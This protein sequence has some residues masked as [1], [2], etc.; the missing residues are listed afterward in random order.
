M[1]SFSEKVVLLQL[2]YKKRMKKAI[3]LFTLMFALAGCH[4]Q[5]AFMQQLVEIDSTASQK[6]DSACMIMLD[7]I[8]PETIDNDECLAYYW[9]LKTRTEIRLEKNIKSTSAINQAIS[10]YKKHSKNDI[11]AYAYV[12]KASILE[13]QERYLEA[14]PYLKM[15][16]SFILYVEDKTDFSYSIYS[17]LAHINHQAKEMDLTISYGKQALKAAYQQN[18]KSNISCAMMNLYIYHDDNGMKDSAQYYL[19]RLKP[20]IKDIPAKRRAP[21]YEHRGLSLI[22]EDLASAEEYLN[23]AHILCPTPNTYEGLARIYYKKG[24]REKAYEMWQK[25]LQ[26]N[27]LY[28]KAEILQTMYESQREEGNY[29]TASET[30]MRIACIK[31]SIAINKKGGDILTIQEQFDREL[32]G[33]YKLSQ[34]SFVISIVSNLLLLAVIVTIYFIYRNQKGRKQQQATQQQLEQYRNQL[35]LLEKEGKTDT[36]EVERLTQKIAELQAKQGAQLQNGRERYEEVMTGGTTVRWSRNDFSDCIEY[37]RTQDA[38]FVARM[39]SDYRH[40][41][42]KYIFFALMEHLGKTDEELQHLMAISQNTV[43]SYRSRINSAEIQT[44]A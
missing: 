26:T 17:E 15:A 34:S 5:N 42:A 12:Y 13:K 28:Q 39:E 24:K 29:K 27:D 23:K 20:I 9:L 25:A 14:I 31:D 2:D 35:K 18:S 32:Q 1:P 8:L 30:A 16:E 40:L 44:Q 7:R 33:S 10:Y 38:A 4:R 21:F 37:Y 6:G 19:E 22:E 36:K 43:R 41:S 3:Y 11:L